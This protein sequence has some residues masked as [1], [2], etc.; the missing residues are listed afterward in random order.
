MPR[1][2]L[3]HCLYHYTTPTMGVVH[4]TCFV[5]GSKSVGNH[6]PPICLSLSCEG[7]Q[8]RI[9]GPWRARLTFEGHGKAPSG[10]KKSLAHSA[11][12][13]CPDP[14]PARHTCKISSRERIDHPEPRVVVICVPV[15]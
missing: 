2:M 14:G 15:A 8:L 7:T 12:A 13:C 1:R 6:T 11:N 10:D 4:D 3:V 9:S 5:K